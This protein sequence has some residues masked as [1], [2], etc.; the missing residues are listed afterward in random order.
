M[1]QVGIC[2]VGTA[3]RYKICQT[4]RDKTIAAITVHLHIR[5]ERAFV[6]RAEMPEH[7]IVGQFLKGRTGEVGGI[8]H[9]QQV[10]K[11]VGAQLLNCIFGDG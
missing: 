7:A 3:K 6:E 9:E 8:P 2:D 11:M 4:F 10:R 5:D 1:D